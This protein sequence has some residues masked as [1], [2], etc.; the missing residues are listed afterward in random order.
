MP[1]FIT[2]DGL[3]L[4]YTDTGGT[5]PVVICLSGLTRNGT[6]FEVCRAAFEPYAYDH[7]GLSW[8][9][10]VRLGQGFPNLFDPEGSAGRGRD[11]GC[12]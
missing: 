3:S 8:P 7:A 9:W 6:D 12:A 10:Q 11:D 5:G 4:H 1:R 2:S